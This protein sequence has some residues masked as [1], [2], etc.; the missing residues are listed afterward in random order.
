MTGHGMNRR[1]ARGAL[2]L[3][4]AAALAVATPAEAQVGGKGFLF[5]E[6]RWTFAIRGGFDRASA[7]GGLF[8]FVTDELTLE[9]KDF[10]GLHLAA[11]IALRIM[12]RVDLAIGVT[13]AGSTTP[14]ESRK[15][16]G[17]DDLPI[18]QTT[19][20]ARTAVTGSLKG[21]L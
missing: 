9:R 2:L 1:S 12:P 13:H 5:Q 14:S 10:S 16:V 21:Y 7:S 20:F 6:P 19:K 11:D 3:A 8:E 15:F 4:G 18:L 17:T